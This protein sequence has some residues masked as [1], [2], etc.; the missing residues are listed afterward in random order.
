[1]CEG[2]K[3]I[4]KEPDTSIENFY[5]I[6]PKKENE[7]YI[8][9]IEIPKEWIEKCNGSGKTYWFNTNTYERSYR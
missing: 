9:N 8:N 1:M 2:V 6:V 3:E 4:S 5:P 7:Q